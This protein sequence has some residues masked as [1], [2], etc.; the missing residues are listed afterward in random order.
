VWRRQIKRR[1]PFAKPHR[2]VCAQLSEEKSRRASGALSSGAAAF[3][4]LHTATSTSAESFVLRT[5][6]MMNDT[7]KQEAAIATFATAEPKTRAHRGPHP[8]IVAGVFTALFIA[9]LLPVTLLTGDSHFP[10]PQQSPEEV[11]AYFRENAER[12]R[13]CAFLQFGSAV[14]LGIFTATMVSR[15]RFHGIRAA[16]PTIALLGGFLATL[17]VIVSSLVV[18]VLSQPG[19]AAASELTRALHY[20]AFAMGGPGYSVPFGLLVAGVSV[21]AGFAKLLPRW[22]VVFGLGLAAAGELSA[23]DLVVPGALFL[24]PLTRFPGFVW[25]VAAGFKLPA[26]A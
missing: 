20:F 12:V 19:I 7:A 25:L 26:R 8:G 3:T 11:I 6:I 18:W 13:W 2:G 24:I 4:F 17:S 1:H 10:A 15:L 9:G 21:S 23:L 22:L 16:G 5:I 14:P